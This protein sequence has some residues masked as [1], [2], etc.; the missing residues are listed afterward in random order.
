MEGGQDSENLEEFHRMVVSILD[1]AELN[2][3]MKSLFALEGAKN[4]FGVVLPEKR[5][6]FVKELE[7]QHFKILEAIEQKNGEFAYFYMKEHTTYIGRIYE[8]YFELLRK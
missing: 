7:E 6:K 3:I 8:E 5:E 2:Q 4:S 1:N